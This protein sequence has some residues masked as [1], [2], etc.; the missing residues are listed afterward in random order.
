[1]PPQLRSLFREIS[2]VLCERTLRNTP[3]QIVEFLNVTAD[4]IYNYHR[5]VKGY[6]FNH[7]I[8]KVRRKLESLKVKCTLRV[9][10]QLTA[11]NVTHYVTTCTQKLVQAAIKMHIYKL[12]GCF[13]K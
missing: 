12:Q 5:Y 6:V 13:K 4:D 9:T 3:S 1:M 10:P 8:Q 2:G 11:N 7:F